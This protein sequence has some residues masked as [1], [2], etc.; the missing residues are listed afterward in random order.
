MN[1]YWK[2]GFLFS[3][4]GGFATGALADLMG[5]PP[6]ALVRYFMGGLT[7]LMVWNYYERKERLEREHFREEDQS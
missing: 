7:G 1:K 4:L 6:N 5:F 2:R 3:L